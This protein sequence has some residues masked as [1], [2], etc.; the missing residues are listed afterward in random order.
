MFD[1]G[2]EKL[3]ILAVVALFILGPERLPTA[4]AWLARTLRQLKNYAN[5]ANEKI[6]SELGPGFDEMREPLDDLRSELGGLRTW[7]NPRAA[8]LRHLSDDPIAPYRYPPPL[9][10]WE[11]TLN[12]Y[13]VG[14]PLP[15]AP[16]ER[17]PIDP[18]AT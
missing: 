10:G 14:P 12:K 11:P 13:P 4:A 15:L 6:R 8:L 17:P 18:D 3:F 7:R 16:G 1:L 5:D 2:I 9:D